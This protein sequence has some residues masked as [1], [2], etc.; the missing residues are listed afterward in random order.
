MT[1]ITTAYACSHCNTAFTAENPCRCGWS[2]RVDG[3]LVTLAVT[4]LHQEGR[5]EFSDELLHAALRENVPGLVKMKAELDEV[6]GTT[7]MGDI[8]LDEEVKAALVACRDEDGARELCRL[9]I[10]K[11]FGP[12]RETEILD[13]AA[14]IIQA[15]VPSLAPEVHGDVLKNMAYKLDLISDRIEGG[16]P[17][18]SLTSDMKKLGLLEENDG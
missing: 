17:E 3:G 9:L 8:D 14:D 4:Q 5:K 15:L 12:Q 18:L 13:A 16:T 1:F 11:G 7:P 6:F 10:R 2:H